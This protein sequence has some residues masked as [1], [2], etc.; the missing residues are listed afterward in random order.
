MM[1]SF[2]SNHRIF[3]YSALLVP[4]DSYNYDSLQCTCSSFPSFS[5]T[6]IKTIITPGRPEGVDYLGAATEQLRLQLAV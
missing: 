4:C 6:E 2:T 3:F 5:A 1:D